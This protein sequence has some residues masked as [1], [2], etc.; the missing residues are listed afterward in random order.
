MNSIT[1]SEKIE[2]DTVSIIEEEGNRKPSH[3]LKF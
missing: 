2:K 1:I 3:N